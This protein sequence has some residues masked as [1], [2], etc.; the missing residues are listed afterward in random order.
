MTEAV[1][2]LDVIRQGGFDASLI[3]TYNA[4]LP[5]YEEVV[6]RRLVA[7]GCR[8]NIVLMDRAQCAASWASVASRPRLAGSA[9]SLLPLDAPGAFHPK[10]CILVGKSKAAILVG[11]HNLTLSGFGCNREIT[12]W[13]QVADRQD[14]A[15][16][17]AV[18]V[19][20]DMLRQCIEQGG[21][22]L[23]ASLVEAVLSVSGAFSRWQPAGPVA[24]TGLL[25][26]Q[27]EE[28]ALID[29][30]HERVAGEVGRVLVTGAFFDRELAFITELER[31]WPAAEL[32]V[33]IDPDSVHLP[34]IKSMQARFV[35]ARAV[36]NAGARA[37]Y[38]HAKALYLEPV[39]GDD[40]V[41]VSGSANPSRQG[42]MGAHGD[43]NI[44]AV[45]VRKGA[46]ARDAAVALGLYHL[47]SLP[48]LTPA[49]LHQ[50]VAR[51][52]KD[53]PVCA[54][55][56]ERLLVGIVG[57]DH[58]LEIS[59]SGPL[60]VD[61]AEF[62]SDDD[63][64]LAMQDCIAHSGGTIRI[65]MPAGAE[66]R[67]R[68]CRLSL[69]ECE[70]ARAMIAYPD[71]LRASPRGDRSQLREVLGKVD[72]SGEDV[73]DLL[74]VVEKA[75]FD[76]AAEREVETALRTRQS[77]Q[78]SA[79]GQRPESLEVI[80]VGPQSNRRRR[81]RIADSTDLVTIIDLLSHAIGADIPP[82][83]GAPLDDA[84][85]TEEE[86]VGAE[87]SNDP[88]EPLER[89]PVV[90]IGDALEQRLR[91]AEIAQ[92]IQSKVEKLVDRMLAKLKQ[93]A[94]PEAQGRA[95][96]QLIAVLLLLHQFMR[97]EQRRR[98]QGTRVSFATVKDR[99][100]LLEGATGLLFGSR[101]RLIQTLV[102]GQGPSGETEENF[103]LTIL[104]LW[105]AWS[106]DIDVP[107]A[108]FNAF[109]MQDDPQAL[110]AMVLFLEL[111]P[112]VTVD[113]EAREQLVRYVAATHRTT[114][115]ATA[116]A[117]KWLQAA[118]A[119]GRRWSG[120][121]AEAAEVRR[122][123][124]CWVG[125]CATPRLIVHVVGDS[126]GIWDDVQPRVIQKSRVIAV[127]PAVQHFIAGC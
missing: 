41:I 79:A 58:V 7:A 99:R 121:A 39:S 96:V 15:G 31:R 34:A 78:P 126:V 90:A 107:R 49:A 63:T 4:T 32:V 18:H 85:R 53:P 13:I 81:V 76:E 44:E 21:R 87:D 75:L 117:Q 113:E 118:V 100:R 59:C 83:T 91:D 10:V 109:S 16:V 110:S 93:A 50:V 111:A 86:Q 47:L 6:L 64:V 62:L 119:F 69:R 17:A 88:S 60:E 2:L 71:A 61:G 120:D 25:F 14:A 29:M 68:S 94:K 19:A 103:R 51:C 115:A 56:G 42:W 95:I 72:G 123:G 74:A 124:C 106:V 22:H 38:L 27:R 122:G 40:C 1:G 116:Q 3:T 80:G 33:A 114:P 92:R 24:D 84:G 70:V 125:D 11:S 20:W 101:K 30:L 112:G 8:Q 105:L 46:V 102:P 127:Q 108:A 52:E 28:R 73:E 67:I 26:Q 65:A 12:N 43:G 77:T 55:A 98:S 82:R 23:P 104:L 48:A 54:G 97:A 5:F 37:Q 89:P 45:L 36:W 35:D 9:Y 57:S 66:R